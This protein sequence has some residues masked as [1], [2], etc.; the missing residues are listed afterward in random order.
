MIQAS[1]EIW[2]DVARQY[3]QEIASAERELAGEIATLL[4]GI[5]LAPPARLIEIGAGSGHLSLL[6]QQQ[7]YTTT[8]LDF[9]PIA[10]EHARGMYAAHGYS[11][12]GP[13]EANDRF[14]LGDAFDLPRMGLGG[15]DLA[16]NSGVCEHFDAAQL[17]R[18]LQSMA[19][20]ARSV[21]IIVPNPHSVFYLAGRRRAIEHC[22]W[23]YGVELLR[24]NY[25]QVFHAAG[26]RRVQHGFLGRGMTRDWIRLAVGAEAAP[27]FEKLLDE[28]QMPQRE[29]YLQY[30]MGTAEPEPTRDTDGE[31]MLPPRDLDSDAFDRTLSL[32]ALGTTMIALSKMREE[33]DRL[34]AKVAAAETARVAAQAEATNSARALDEGRASAA[35]A[36]RA[37]E[38][39]RA[40]AAVLAE[41]AAQAERALEEARAEAAVLAEKVAHAETAQDEAEKRAAEAA[42]HIVKLTNL[43]DELLLRARA[44]ETEREQVLS[45]TS[46]RITA[47]LRRAVVAIRQ[48]RR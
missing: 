9:S 28:G 46:W 5:G 10:L 41:R 25:E 35:Q 29:F 22:R 34:K 40:E 3:S 31:R 24:R 47:P 6:L 15:F 2:D 33:I 44:A 13:A 48:A 36:E 45:S 17:Q 27:L 42:H 38:E 26:I 37:L 32:D 1:P 8:L 30:F 14:I 4:G 20:V 19:A 43:C 12:G 21:L 39:A 7:G 16:W 23:I 18:M 11:D